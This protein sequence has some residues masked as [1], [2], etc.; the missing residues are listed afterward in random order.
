M[1]RKVTVNDMMMARDSRASLQRKMTGRYGTPVIS[2]TMNIA[3]PVKTGAAIK[4]TF[5]WGKERL[6][7]ELRKGSVGIKEMSCSYAFTG[8]E[9]MIACDS[10][11]S[12]LK[13]I[14]EAIEEGSPAGRL[15]DMDVVLP[16]GTQIRREHERSCIVCGKTGKGCSSRRTHSLNEILEATERLIR[17]QFLHFDSIKAGKMV[18]KAL[19]E[20]VNTTPKPGL[21][22]RNNNGS[23]SDMDPE[24]FK[25]SASSLESYFA[26]CFAVGAEHRQDRAEEVFEVI[27]ELG[28]EAEKRMF[29]VT[30]GVNTH[31]GA[32]YTL[33][34]ISCAI[35][36][37][38]E[39]GRPERDPKVIGKE[40]SRLTERSVTEHFEGLSEK[41]ARTSGDRAYLEYGL[42]GIRG[43]A[44]EGLP[45]VVSVSLPVFRECME[46][47]YSLN[48]SAVYAL[49]HLIA[50]GKDTNM[51]ARGGKERAERASEAVRFLTEK[52]KY[53]PLKQ[54]EEL[55][56]AF[57]E[58]NLSPG[59]CADL[60]AATIFLYEWCCSEIA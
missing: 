46:N 9:C 5:D 50:L 51:Y 47:G 33:G 13:K 37:L 2:F 10:K 42:K 48:D 38:W 43:E 40:C 29:S 4:R 30:G 25:K 35:G 60:L 20:E 8:Y 28:T 6:L 21:V 17:E 39:P 1:E 45:S 22:D 56:M 16:D 23:H 41:K 19:N 53:P 59:G 57:M 18:V 32:I 44:A 3:G 11:G 7:E 24:L 58:E 26:G 49:L 54:I 27:K 14:C 15:F 31:K 55:D 12:A 34:I 52:E 36:R